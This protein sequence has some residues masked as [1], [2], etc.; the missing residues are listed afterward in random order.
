MEIE[1]LS[2]N[3]CLYDD[4]HSENEITFGKVCLYDLNNKKEKASICRPI[5]SKKSSIKIASKSIYQNDVR[6]TS[7]M[8]DICG[9]QIIFRFNTLFSVLHL[10]EASLPNYDLGSN[11]PNQRKNKEINS[12]R[13]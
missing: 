2:V 11:K 8:I 3:S 13:L 7:T 5:D 4:L 12:F 1:N 6:Q 9:Q 10:I